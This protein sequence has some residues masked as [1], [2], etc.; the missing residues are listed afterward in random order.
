[1]HFEAAGLAQKQLAQKL[2]LAPQQ[3]QRTKATRYRTITLSR[4]Q[5]VAVALGVRVKGEIEVGE[6]A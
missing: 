2:G 4:M 3:I 6:V 5:E 1:M